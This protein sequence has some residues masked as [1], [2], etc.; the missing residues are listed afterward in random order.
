MPKTLGS[1]FQDISIDI[2]GEDGTVNPNVKLLAVNDALQEIQDEWELPTTQFTV[3]IDVFNF[4]WKYPVPD[5]YKEFVDLRQADVMRDYTDFN[6]VTRDDFWRNYRSSNQVSE[7]WEGNTRLLLISLYTIHLP[8]QLVDPMD[9]F[10]IDGTWVADP[11]SGAKNVQTNFLYYRP[12]TNSSSV[13]WDIDVNLNSATADVVK[14]NLM[15]VDLSG[16]YL[17][18]IGEFFL[19]M[20]LPN[21]SNYSSFELEIGSDSSNFYR[22]SVTTQFAK[23]PFTKGWNVLGFDWTT[24]T[25]VGTPNNAAITF[26]RVRANYPAG[27]TSQIGLSMNNLICR[28]RLSM[29]LDLA[30]EFIVTDGST[31]QLKRTFASPTD[32]NSYLNIPQPFENLVRYKAL[33]KIFTTH[34][35]DP[36]AMNKFMAKEQ[37]IQD[38]LLM[39]YPSKRQPIMVSYSPRLNIQNRTF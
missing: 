33:V 22:M 34:I 37:T 18:G 16:Q 10:N 27:F 31:G 19:Q 11:G 9:F 7:E 21:S 28:A 39:K 13:S 4:N 8:S 29:D 6:N 17:S 2:S 25:T 23:A 1:I 12:D 24:A 15:P 20:Y 36:I 26:V 30:S 35:D 5:G 14:S 32:S 38:A 3:P